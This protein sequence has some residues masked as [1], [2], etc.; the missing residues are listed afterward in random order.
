MKMTFVGRTCLFTE[1]DRMATICTHTDDIS[2]SHP[3]ARSYAS[4]A[5]NTPGH[6]L[7]MIYN[8]KNKKYSGYANYEVLGRTS[9]EVLKL[10]RDLVE[11][12][13]GIKLISFS[14]LLSHWKR[15][16]ATT[17]QKE[18]ALFIL[19]SLSAHVLSATKR[20]DLDE[21]LNQERIHCS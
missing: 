4:Q 15:R 21:V 20:F 7:Q 2:I 19:N 13:A 8:K 18:N 10:V 17:F 5:C 14:R 9:D 11:K 12:A 16:I 6:Y 1:W 3:C